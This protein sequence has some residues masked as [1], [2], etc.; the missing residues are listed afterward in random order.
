MTQKAQTTQQRR[1][2][3]VGAGSSGL[4][5]LKNAVDL[6][7]PQGWE[8]VCFDKGERFIGCWGNPH[9][10]FVSTST[11]Y[12][13]QFACFQKFAAETRPN[14]DSSRNEFFRDD[15]Y[16]RYL[17][18]FAEAFHL[19]RYI[20]PHRSVSD[21]ER[22]A[23]GTWQLRSLDH[24]SKNESF[25][26]FDAVILC[27]GLAAEPKPVHCSIPTVAAADLNQPGY[28]E[29]LTHRTVVVLG[30]G[31]SAVDFANRVA[32]SELGN[33]VILSLQSGIRV[34]PRYHPI[35]GVPSDFLRNRL[36]LSIHEDIRNWIGE[37]FVRARIRYQEKFERWF[38]QK[39]L[40]NHTH[41]S[42]PNAVSSAAN[43][44]RQLRSNW[45]FRLTKAA[46]DDLFNMFH[47]KSDDFLDAVAEERITIVGP[48]TDPSYSAFHPFDQ[49]AEGL[50]TQADLVIP[51]V[52]FK[53]CLPKVCGASLKLSDFFLGCC[54]QH[55]T[56]LFLVGFARPIIGN[57]P[58]I[59]EMQAQY[60]CGLLADKYSHPASFKE[61]H[62]TETLLRAQRFQ[63]LNLQAVYPVEMFPYC[64]RL[65]KLMGTFPSLRKIGSLT[66]WWR[67][68][69]TPATTLHYLD[70]PSRALRESS[71]TQAYLPKRLILLLLALKPLDWC[72]RL[73]HCI[74]SK[75]TIAPEK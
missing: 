22:N 46:K 43:G 6:L 19:R 10:G 51:A 24:S 2:A 17:E 12:T 70:D 75:R 13:T 63:A 20:L 74:L 53:A 14:H 71:V 68:Q 49:E 66:A 62:R 40:A 21:L 32:R 42:A 8:I 50:S 3:I 28:L 1:L 38:P 60:V 64:D 57:I 44:I 47:N 52:G 73:I 34:S 23:D 26:R 5:C 18:E 25:E 7:A 59:S 41:A 69:V 39:H 67:I 54:H 11:K 33:R 4:I 37:R 56:N 45:A 65:A 29:S 55:N 16:G 35:R 30:G 48:P 27:T 9:K 31:E 72:Y 58:S 61:L 15:E 36:M